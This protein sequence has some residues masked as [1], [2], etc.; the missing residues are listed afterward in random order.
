VVD[1]KI[2]SILDPFMDNIFENQ[3]NFIDL[4]F[5]KYLKMIEK[6]ISQ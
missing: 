3:L 6:D 2:S 5:E 4:N 1:N